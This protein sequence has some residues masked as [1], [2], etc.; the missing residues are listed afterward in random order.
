[1]VVRQTAGSAGKD[2]TSQ[3][4]HQSALGLREDVEEALVTA[5]AYV[6]KRD[7][8]GNLLIRS[9]A[10]DPDNPR[11]WPNWRRYAVVGLPCLLNNLVSS[12]AIC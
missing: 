9:T 8:Q 12:P 11:S 7:E 6:F 3:V 2:K 10:D 4:E 5:H 1:M